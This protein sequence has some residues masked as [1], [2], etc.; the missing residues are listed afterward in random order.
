MKPAR[1]IAAVAPSGLRLA[2]QT[3]S[4]ARHATSRRQPVCRSCRRL[5]ASVADS[6]SST[7]PKIG[8][9][10]HGFTVKNVRAVPELELTAFHFQ[11][12]K[13]G[14]EYL[15]LAKDDKNNVFSIG[16]K[17]NP[18]DRTGVPHILEHLTLCGSKRYPVRDPFFKMMPRSLNN[19][20]NAMTYPEHTV[21]PF[22]TTNHQDFKNLMSVYM[23]ATLHPLLREH[24]FAQEG[25]RLGPGDPKA[26][27]S[28]EN[29]IEFKGVVYNEMKGNMSSADYLFST[30]WQDHIFPSLQDSG[31]DPQK[32][33]DLTYDSLRKF[34]AEHY[35]PSNSRILTYGDMSVADH[36]AFLGP[37]MNE[38][39]K[40]NIDRDLKVPISLD[41]GSQTV[42]VKGPND[43]LF[44]RD[45]QYKASVS[46]I[47]NDTSDVL[48]TFALDIISS[49]MLEG[50]S[51]P[52]YRN[53]IEVGWGA[54]YA[55]NTGYDSS[56][57]TGIF[58]VG[59]N[60]LK[61]HDISRLNDGLKNTFLSVRRQGF[62]DAKVEGHLHQIELSLKNK[63][64]HFGMG[65]TS[66]LQN[67]WFNGT[68]PFDAMSPEQIVSAFRERI[69]DPTYLTS[70]L[71]KYWINGNTFTFVME[72]TEDF[73]ANL[74]SEEASRLQ[75]KIQEV[76]DK[77][78][79]PEE[80]TKYLEQRELD[81]LNTQ[82]SGAGEDVSCL[83]SINVSDIPRTTER[84]DVRVAS[85]DGGNSIH[86]R[87]TPTNGLTYF[88][89]VQLFEHLPDDLRVYL[90][91][92]SMAIQRLGTP[93]MPVETLE[94]L[95]R[96]R[97][98]GLST[99]L[100]ASTAPDD[101]TRTSEGFMFAGTA[102]DRN[103][104]FMLELLTKV[105]HETDFTA[106][107]AEA[108]VSEL[109]KNV[110][111]SAINDVAD[112]GH[113]YA[114][115]FAEAGISEESRLGEEQAGLTQI[116]LMMDLAGRPERAGLTDVMERLQAIQA[117]VLS[118]SAPMRI[119][120]TCGS[121]ATA[122]N[123]SAVTKFLASLP[124]GVEPPKVTEQNLYPRDAK[125]FFPLPY[126][127]YYSALA[128]STTHYTH[129]DSPHLSVLSTLLTHKRLHPEV[130]EKGG[131]YGASAYAGAL[132]GTF[133][134]TSY[135]DP[136]PERSLGVMREAGQWAA[137]RAWTKQE[138][139]EAKLSVFQNVDAPESVVNEGMSEFLHGITPD[140]KQVRREAFL[141]VSAAQV[142]AVADKYLSKLAQGET[143]SSVAVL[144]PRADWIN[145][146]RG[147]IEMPLGAGEVG[148]E[149][150]D[151]YIVL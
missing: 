54:S 55:P 32:M 50:F 109:I 128:T 86:W 16:F 97:T 48:E 25:W 59:L 136:T 126:Q 9:S 8:D 68:D 115:K 139:D 74:E 129:P 44:P 120:L 103:V 22:A 102:L 149:K 116:R 141:D 23:D 94:D 147:W 101:I 37:Q 47:M 30:R 12:D 80:A 76:N 2:A 46:W 18:P 107:N 45:Q 7:A 15:H 67:G 60:G 88:R 78:K 4:A 11:H 135:R 41:Q 14:G 113:G 125:S 89:A 73:G 138:I 145:G 132:R 40:A 70:L 69:Q 99:G 57:K 27:A 17:T 87:E 10:L 19:F 106:R 104:P 36:L 117:F 150:E 66:R 53:T 130:R 143:D 3:P 148:E 28:A 119:A 121:E 24:D 43:P 81:L 39:E 6:T 98:G 35:N 21:Y 110:A 38:F 65:I 29:P 114:R 133:G 77:F 112:S 134:F 42:S 137:S 71:E 91:L 49:L 83:P 96:L 52:I 79:T 61:K 64:A 33:T 93:S 63:T 140:M 1:H 56:A 144:G 20:M 26:P 108:K 90:P 75:S 118:G 151:G 124:Q 146:E 122:A 58:T 51:A 84:K 142:Q 85:L 82:E 95:T 92:F 123:E 72:P 5:F 127:V 105:I 131:A 13:T 31:G 111:S 62:Q 100:Y 34:Q